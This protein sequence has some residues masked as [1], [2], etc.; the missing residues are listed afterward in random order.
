MKL[1]SKFLIIILSCFASLTYA[2]QLTQVKYDALLSQYMKIIQDTKVVLDSDDTQATFS[3]QNKAF[4]ERIIAYQNIKRISED[5]RQLENASTMLLAAN[6]Y[7][8]RQSKS[9]E[10]DGFTRNSFCKTK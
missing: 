5:N 8:E 2:E 1:Y 10:L 3:E 9:L 7:L 6:Y 4:C